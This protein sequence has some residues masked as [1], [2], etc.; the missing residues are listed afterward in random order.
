MTEHE[1]VTSVMNLV[2]SHEGVTNTSLSPEQVA[3]E[4]D[5]L[6][7]RMAAD[8]DKVSLFRRPYIGFTQTIKSLEVKRTSTN[9]RYVDIPK[10]M[11]K[12]DGNPAFLYIGGKDEKSPYRVIT[13]DQ[14]QN[15]KYDQFIGKS[16]IANYNE[17]HIE[18]YNVVPNFIRV[19]AVF[20]DPSALE[21]L[22][23]WDTEVNDY[24]MP[25]GMIDELIGKTVNSYINTMYRV[26]VQPNTQTDKPVA[27]TNARR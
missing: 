14:I 7:G 26:G 13:G 20:E 17:G 10:M 22:G 1:I 3:L 18:F 25:T 4:V 21:L 23:I 24:P 6:R 27:A 19:I 9:Q 8:M 12:R 5:S 16:P 15:V 2:T 11:I